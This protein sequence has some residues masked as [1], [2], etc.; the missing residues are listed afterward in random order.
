MTCRLAQWQVSVV[1]GR[2]WL[3]KLAAMTLAVVL[4]GGGRDS[5]S[6]NDCWAL[7]RATG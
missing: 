7:V 5:R 3:F 6:E 4:T 1:D 2:F